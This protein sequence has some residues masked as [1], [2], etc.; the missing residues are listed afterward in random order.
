V[1]F[2]GGVDAH[3]LHEFFKA[4]LFAVC[5]TAFGGFDG[6][7]KLAT[8]AA[9]VLDKGLYVLLKA[10]YGLL[11]LRVELACSLKARIEINVRLINFAVSTQNR[12]SLAGE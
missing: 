2:G 6:V 12:V 7:E 11:H 5:A 3:A 8:F 9:A 1:R 10:F 4:S